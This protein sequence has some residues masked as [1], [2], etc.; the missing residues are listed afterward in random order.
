MLIN[1]YL[2]ISSLA[3]TNEAI[4]TWKKALGSGPTERRAVSQAPAWLA[5]R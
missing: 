5:W 2:H 4:R 1:S 3:I